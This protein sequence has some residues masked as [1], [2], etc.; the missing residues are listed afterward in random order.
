MS[1]RITEEEADKLR[2]DIKT[3]EKMRWEQY[4]RAEMWWGFCILLII[5]VIVLGIQLFLCNCPHC[6]SFR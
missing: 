1:E 4:H 2:T 5:V 6:F 3:L